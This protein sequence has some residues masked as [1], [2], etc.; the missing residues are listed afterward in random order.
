MKHPKVLFVGCDKGAWQM[1][2]RQMAQV[3]GARYTSK[4]QPSDWEWADVIVL[5]KRAVDRWGAEAMVTGKVLIWDV[6]DWWKQPEDNQTPVAVLR[7]RVKTIQRRYR[8]R[9]VIG[10]T[11]AMADAIGGVYIPHH[12]RIGLMP[13]PIRAEATTVAYDGSPRYLGSWAGVIEAACQRLGLRFVI[14]P[15]DLSTADVLVAFRGEEWDGEVC[16]Q[17]KSGVKYVNAIAAGR[18][19]LTQDVSSFSEI[20]PVGFAVA[21]PGEVFE[22]IRAMTGSRALRELAYDRGI[23][24]APQFTRE[25]IADQYRQVLAS[26]VRRAA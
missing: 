2:G 17:W 8:I 7:E 21:E 24:R 25:V 12:C 19:V 11:Q 23:A 1:R 18:P 22:A 20:N 6:L 10:A 26:A 15:K 13:T 4:P 3:L 9:T 14:N 5:V 16:R